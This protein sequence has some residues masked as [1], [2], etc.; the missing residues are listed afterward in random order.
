MTKPT[1][2]QARKIAP[3]RRMTRIAMEFGQSRNSKGV[4]RG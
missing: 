1:L 4:P 2:P 3:R